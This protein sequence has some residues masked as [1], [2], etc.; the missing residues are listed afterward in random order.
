LQISEFGVEGR[1]IIS[2]A[3]ASWFDNFLDYL[4]QYDL[5]FA[6]WPLVGYLENNQGDGWALMNWD[7]NTGQRNGLYDGNDWR[8]ERWSEL[9][10]ST[11]LTGPVANSTNWRMLSIDQGDYIKSQTLL[12]RGDW[13]AGSLKAACPDDLRLIGLSHE[14]DRGL[15]TDSTYGTQLW[16]AN[17]DTVIVR[18]QGNI[19]TDWASSYT[20][21]QCP[22]DHYVIGYSIHGTKVSTIVCAASDRQGGLGTNA[23]TIWFNRG[24]SRTDG[25]TGGDWAESDY[26]GQCGGN[27]YIAGVAFTTKNS[28]GYPAALL[29]QS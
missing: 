14:K 4:Q 16:N 9:I 7:P 17:K 1:G 20:K 18:N 3:E 12:S 25:N 28:P 19:T 27:E 2:T 24:D 13:D 21:L 15:C 6:I 22:Q 10:N 11:S 23:R 26:K 29:C 8:A 5:D